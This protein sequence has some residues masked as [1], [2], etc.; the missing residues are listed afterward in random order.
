MN[1]AML[2]VPIIQI[3]ICFPPYLLS[4]AIFSDKFFMDQI[5]HG[6]NNSRSWPASNF[7]KTGKVSVTYNGPNIQTFTKRTN[8]HAVA[9]LAPASLQHHSNSKLMENITRPEFSRP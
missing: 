2:L 9:Q 3:K 8:E 5:F 7:Q 4:D 1:T 6:H